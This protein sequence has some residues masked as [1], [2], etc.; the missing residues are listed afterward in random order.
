MPNESQVRIRVNAAAVIQQRG[1][2]LVAGQLLAGSLG[3]KFVARSTSKGDEW[4]VEEAIVFG[5][6]PPTAYDLHE[7]GKCSFSFKPVK[8][9]RAIDEGE[10]FTEVGLQA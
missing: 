5:T 2:V 4:Q 6:G 7:D 10:E 1:L 3:R 8:T 9:I